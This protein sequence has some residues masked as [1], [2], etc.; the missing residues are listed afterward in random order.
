MMSAREKLLKVMDALPETRQYE[1]LDFAR[2]LCWLEKREQEEI[3]DWQRFGMSQLAKCYGPDE[4][5]YTEAD[6]KPELSQ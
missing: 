5:E 1:V 6:I 2:Y 3:A 4:P